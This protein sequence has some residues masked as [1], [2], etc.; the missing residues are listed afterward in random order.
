[1]TGLLRALISLG[2]MI[3]PLDH[4]S[5]LRDE[6][7]AELSIISTQS[8][9][10]AALRFSLGL[11]LGAPMT[12]LALG[13]DEGN[14]F[15]E[16]S[17]VAQTV[18][19]PCTFFVAYGVLSRQLHF[20]LAHT[21]LLVGV[22]LVSIGMCRDLRH[23]L[24]TMWARAGLVLAIVSGSMVTA[25]NVNGEVTNPILSGAFRVYAGSS[26]VMLGLLLLLVSGLVPL[27]RHR[28]IQ[29]GLLFTGAGALVWTLLVIANTVLAATWVDRTFQIVTAPT[30]IA[31]SYAAWKAFG[32]PE[33]YGI[34]G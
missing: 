6:W 9:R 7:N 21:G 20:L 12:A 28:S 18:L 14:P 25:I 22:T 24:E 31:A 32:R 13:A 16:T 15:R 29:I 17:I 33:T 26:V 23:P 10:L 19:L 34:P 30:L 2:S 8:G 27:Y 4:R 5:R 11:L 1:M 3:L